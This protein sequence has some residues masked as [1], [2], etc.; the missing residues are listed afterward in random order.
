MA[1]Y[2]AMASRR[3]SKKKPIKSFSIISVA[4]QWCKFINLGILRSLNKYEPIQTRYKFRNRNQMHHAYV[5][6][7][8]HTPAEND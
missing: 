4:T 1:P 8:G 7:D 2:D 6:S 5:K 3:N